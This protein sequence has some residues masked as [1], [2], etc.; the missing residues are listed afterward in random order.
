[1][2]GSHELVVGYLTELDLFKKG[3]NRHKSVRWL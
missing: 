1:V 3:R 2:N